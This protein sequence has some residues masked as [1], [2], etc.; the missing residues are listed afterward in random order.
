[1]DKIINFFGSRLAKIFENRKIIALW[2]LT[3]GV[4]WF[5]ACKYSHKP[6]Q[7]QPEPVLVEWE[8]EKDF[9]EKRAKLANGLTIMVFQEGE[10][11]NKTWSWSVTGAAVNEQDAVQKVLKMGGIK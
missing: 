8:V 7:P 6:P 10:E 9:G 1:M 11:A 4:S 3:M 5:V 2:L